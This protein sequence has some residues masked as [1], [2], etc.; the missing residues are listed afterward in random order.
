MS[1]DT[2]E[3]VAEISSSVSSIPP[4]AHAPTPAPGKD[5]NLEAQENGANLDGSVYVN[6]DRGSCGDDEVEFGGQDEVLNRNG[7]DKVVELS[8]SKDLSAEVNGSLAAVNA[9]GENCKHGNGI[10]SITGNVKGVDEMGQNES[11]VGG[12][13]KKDKVDDD[14]EEVDEEEK[15]DGDEDGD[16]GHNKLEFYAG[17]IVWGKVR[18]NPWWPGQIYDPSDASDYAKKLQNSKKLLVAYFGDGSFSWCSSYQLKPFAENFEKMS[19]QNTSRKLMHAVEEALNEIGRL[20]ES[21]MSCC[22]SEEN[23]GALARPLAVN[24]GIR[25]GVLVP[26]FDL[27]EIPQ[28][29]PVKIIPLFRNIATNASFSCMLELMVM[30]SWLSA[31]YRAKGKN[32]LAMFSEPLDIEGLEDESSDKLVDV[33]GPMLDLEKG[34]S[35]EDWTAAP[36][37]HEIGELNQPRLQKRV[38]IETDKLPK[39]RKRKSVAKLMKEDNVVEPNNEMGNMEK[40]QKS[41]KRKTREPSKD[42]GP[43]QSVCEVDSISGRKRG[44]K[45][46][47]I[48][49]SLEEVLSTEGGGSEDKETEDQLSPV[50][51]DDGNKLVSTNGQRKQNDLASLK[52]SGGNVL[53]AKNGDSGG[54]LASEKKKKE[55]IIKKVDK[56]AI[57]ET[58]SKEKREGRSS[59]K[60]SKRKSVD[61]SHGDLASPLQ[62][63][64]RKR[65]KNEASDE[66]TD[67][68][69]SAKNGSK[70]KVIS[71][72]NDKGDETKSVPAKDKEPGTEKVDKIIKGENVNVAASG[73][74]MTTRS[75]VKGSKG[76][77]GDEASNYTGE[78]LSS[79]LQKMT[80]KRKM[81]DKSESLEG[82]VEK[83][84]GKMERKDKVISIENDNQEETGNVRMSRVR[85]KSMYLS[86]PFINI[87]SISRSLS[88]KTAQMRDRMSRVSSQ[89]IGS[90]PTLNGNNESQL[91]ILS[92]E[93]DTSIKASPNS[94]PRPSKEG[95]KIIDKG[96]TRVADQSLRSTSPLYSDDKPLHDNPSNK[97]VTSVNPSP[98]P[99]PRLSKEEKKIIDLVLISVPMK[100]VVSEVRSAALN[101]LSLRDKNFLD[102]VVRFIFAYRTVNYLHGPYY[103]IY[104]NTQQGGKREHVK[105][106]SELV[107]A[108]DKDTNK[109][110]SKPVSLMVIF[111]PGFCLPSKSDLI[112]NFG[113]FGPVNE[114]ETDV[115]NESYCAKVVFLTNSDTEKAFNTCLKKNPF[116]SAKVS[117]RLRYS[118]SASKV[119]EIVQNPDMLGPSAEF[120][121]SCL[122]FI[123]RKLEIMTSMV[124]DCGGSMSSELMVKLEN[125]MK[126]L[127]DNI[128]TITKS[129]SA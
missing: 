31:F 74:K 12:G 32:E 48:I 109:D 60:D 20:V 80:R 89:V 7:E 120:E 47:E 41:Q 117:Y 75:S 78:D 43:N 98:N 19:K 56:T 59:D 106:G 36:A 123:K 91:D 49:K 115:S 87:K 23:R 71:I 99:K 73:E 96:V 127:L 57:G 110:A 95:M 107:K 90:T 16:E 92:N 4:Q 88:P 5:L 93:V 30:K 27:S 38:G 100:E 103:K 46:P 122:L 50:K 112:A 82:T 126:E 104:H 65:K 39:R 9:R 28:L 101:P 64:T 37:Q 45:K 81:T 84:G 2:V 54:Q 79:P 17:K 51:K 128:R 24:A 94:S 118:A 18:N 11:I 53:S 113:K 33:S 61:Q 13:G 55:P 83:G 85:K 62:R 52:H 67:K 10:V 124:D 40:A 21:K 42:E 102:T 97:V 116:G 119:N 108:N 44:S 125:E 34:P 58:A 76:K 26:E 35:N 1:S 14:R 8:W 105:T 70:E 25:Q 129:S 66:I 69:G 114:M 86:P 6:G 111:P 121:G 72:G 15:E 63:M 77:I 68:K 29:E 22:I 3:T